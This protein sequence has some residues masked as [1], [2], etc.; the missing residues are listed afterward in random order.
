MIGKVLHIGNN[1]ENVA[2]LGEAAKASKVLQFSPLLNLEIVF[3]AL[4]LTR[5]C[6]LNMDISFS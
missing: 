6:Y 1:G 2:Y 4:K 5:N 3:P